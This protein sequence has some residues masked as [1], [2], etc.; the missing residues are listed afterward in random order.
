VGKILERGE[1]ARAIEDERRAGRSIVFTNGCFDLLH[2]GHVRYLRAA[3]ALGNRLVVGLNSDSS[4][5]RLGKGAGR[6]VLGQAERAEVMAALEMVDYVTVFEED[7]PFELIRVVLPDVLVKGADWSPENV[8]GA[9]VVRSRGGR[10]ELAKYHAGLSTTEIIRR[11]RHSGEPKRTAQ[12]DRLAAE[13]VG[14]AAV[15]TQAKRTPK[16]A[17]QS[18]GRKLGL[19][20]PRKIR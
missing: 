16:S 3:R 14:V 12:T 1:L 13:I 19:S 17:K 4:V 20:R 5:A 7:T 10:V 2:P 9:D 18:G 8:V 15:D 11:I 6:P